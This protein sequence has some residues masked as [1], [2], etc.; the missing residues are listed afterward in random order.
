MSAPAEC[1]IV[2]A[3]SLEITIKASR[4]NLRL[5]LRLNGASSATWWSMSLYSGEVFVIAAYSG[6]SE[7]PRLVDDGS[8]GGIG[9]WLGQTRVD[10]SAEDLAKARVWLEGLQVQGDT[11]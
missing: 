8:P 9:I 2:T 11:P 1:R 7:P 4:S 5:I 3:Q 6:A 10:V